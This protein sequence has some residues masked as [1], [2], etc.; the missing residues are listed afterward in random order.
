MACTRQAGRALRSLTEAGRYRLYC[1]QVQLDCR[2]CFQGRRWRLLCIHACPPGETRMCSQGR[3]NMVA[4]CHWCCRMGSWGSKT[5]SKSGDSTRPPYASL[6]LR[7]F[8][9]APM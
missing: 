6:L 9:T 3:I 2:P 4:V 5:H 7:S 8:F 1:L